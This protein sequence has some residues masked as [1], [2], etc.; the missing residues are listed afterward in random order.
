MLLGAWGALVPFVG[1]YFGYGFTPDN[2]WGWTSARGWLEVAPGAATFLGGALLTMSASRAVALVGGWLAALAGAWFTICIVITPWWNAG[3]IGIPMGD[4]NHMVLERLGM[5]T[6][7][8]VL[9][10]FLAGTA[11][12]RVTVV[13]VRDVEA[14]RTKLDANDRIEHAPVYPDETTTGTT[15]PSTVD[16]T[17]A[18]TGTPATTTTSTGSI[19]R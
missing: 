4:T 18:R 9:I 5:F 1:H 3:S 14:A 11:I 15:T 6:G 2:T 8:G 13:G 17:D 12:G 16:V 10:A 19:R 7:L